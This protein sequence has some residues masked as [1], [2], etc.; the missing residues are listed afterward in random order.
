[1]ARKTT[2]TGEGIRDE[3]VD[4]EDLASGS[5]KAGELNPQVI[6]GQTLITSTD[7]ANDRVLVWDATDSALKQVSPTNLGLGTATPVGSDAQIQYN[8]GGS[9]G[10]A[11]AFYW[12]DANNR[13][14]IGTAAPDNTLH[15]ESPGTTH[16]KI[17]SEEGNFAALKFVAGTGGSTYVWTPADTSDLRFYTN[18]NDRMHIDSDGSVGLE[19]QTLNTR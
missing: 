10:G 4:S 15:V 1:M 2:I 3:T 8:N 13:V 14:G 9:F 5:I 16:I 6:S 18:G 12:D 19:R 7:T 11:A 17:Q